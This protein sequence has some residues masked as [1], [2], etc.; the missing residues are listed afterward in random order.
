[1]K[2]KKKKKEKLKVVTN[3]FY[4]RSLLVEIMLF[5]HHAPIFNHRKFA[6]I[7]WCFAYLP[8]FIFFLIY[9][10]P[11][12]N[13]NWLWCILHLI[14]ALS[15]LSP[16]LIFQSSDRLFSSQEFGKLFAKAY[17][18]GNI[19]GKIDTIDIPPPPPLFS[20]LRFVWIRFIGNSIRKLCTW[21]ICFLIK[22]STLCTFL[23]VWCTWWRI[24]FLRIF[25]WSM[26]LIFLSYFRN[27]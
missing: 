8:F 20:I 10:V 25:R 6:F 12:M 18:W 24:T 21:N 1:M 9:L 27:W 26:Y 17:L 7:A 4:R 19:L 13:S 11:S 14:R 16:Y 15:S 2:K 5:P 3:F 23:I 22:I